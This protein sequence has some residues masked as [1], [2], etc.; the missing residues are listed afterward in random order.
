MIDLCIIGK[1]EYLF[2]VP[3]SWA[4]LTPPQ[5]RAA[6]ECWMR[7]P[8][9]LDYPDALVRRVLGVPK[10]VWRKIPQSQR[11]WIALDRLAFIAESKPVF[12]DNKVPV[13]RVGLRRLH[14][15]DD[16]FSDLTWEEFIYAD[17]FMQRKMFRE[18]ITVLYRPAGL[19]TGKKL[20][21]SDRELENNSHRIDKMDD[22]TVTAIVTCYMAVRKKAVEEKN[23]FI[24]PPSDNTYFDGQLVEDTQQKNSGTE[25]SWADAHHILMGDLAYEEPKFLHSKAT[26]MLNW[27]NRRI[28][29]NREAERKLKKK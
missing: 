10:R 22:A 24:F 16:M 8:L 2:P 14:G 18:A 5:F 4:D 15:F 9:K 29:E 26:T 17:T 6:C 23:R 27:M 19:L 3:D 11:R 7:G 20:P 12:R 1:S 25:A 13:V 21:F 28:K